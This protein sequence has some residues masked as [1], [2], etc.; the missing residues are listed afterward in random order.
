VDIHSYSACAR[1]IS[2]LD[3]SGVINYGNAE[4]MVVNNI[5]LLMSDGCLSE[6]QRQ[7]KQALLLS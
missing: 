3:K 1:A 6:D 4:D 7:E 5:L 2:K